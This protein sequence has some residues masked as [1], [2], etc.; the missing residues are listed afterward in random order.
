MRQDEAASPPATR[1]AAVAASARQAIA[2]VAATSTAKTTRV[3]PS[4]WL[5]MTSMAAAKT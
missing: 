2:A 5:A 3:N 1:T 4:W